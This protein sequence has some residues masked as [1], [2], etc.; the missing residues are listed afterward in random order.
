MLLILNLKSMIEMSSLY[1]I[2]RE[3]R[4]VRLGMNLQMN[5]LMSLNLKI[6]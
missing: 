1:M 4:V 2:W 5:G 6:S 3:P